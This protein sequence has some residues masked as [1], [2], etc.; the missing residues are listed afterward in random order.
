[1][2]SFSGARARVA[3]A[4]LLVLST[5]VGIGLTTA[6]GAGAVT[7]VIIEQDAGILRLHLSNS[8][9]SITY[10]GP[11]Q[12]IPA[13]QSITV[14]GCAVTTGSSLLTLTP[15][16]TKNGMG[17]IKNGLGVRSKNNCATDNGQLS[18]SES[19]TV[20]LGN[21]F[22]AD[23]LVSQAELD[24]EGKH[25]ADL[26][27]AFDG[28]P[29]VVKQLNNSSDNGPDS[30]V[31]DNDRVL[32]DEDFR[33]I[34]LTAAGGAVSLEGGGDGT[35]GQYSASGLVGPIGASIDS[36]DTIF[37]LVTLKEYEDALDCEESLTET[38]VGGVAEAATVTRGQNDGG[39]PCEDV[40]ATLDITGAGVLL[41]KS[42]VSINGTPQ[43]VN[44]E[45]VIVW[46]PQ[47]AVVPLPPR[48]INFEGDPNG[49]FENVQWCDGI[50]P[51]GDVIHPPDAR[52]PSGVLPWCLVSEDLDLLAN[53][54]V[55]QS[56]V[57]DGAGDPLWR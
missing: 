36:A 30:G 46:E 11:L 17:L 37:Q 44:A 14:N 13:S 16:P 45:V 38:L 56:Q 31:G 8:G 27:V 50:A 28:G 47:A 54:L 35:L 18:A 43:A 57:Y 6:L 23:V 2:P 21:A 5:G 4:A 25:S 55:S 34:R 9:S 12:G 39:G 32:L 29:N 53:G 41:D 33:S 40:G 42:T 26:G 19:I 10:T 24:I 22:G 15:N 3:A 20:A 7:P 1:M 51:D 48:Q 52:F 49:M